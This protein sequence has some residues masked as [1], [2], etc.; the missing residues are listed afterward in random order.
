[1]KILFLVKITSEYGDAVMP[2]KSG[3]RN[4]A[5]FVVDA[6]NQ[7]TGVHAVL[8]LCRD[9]NSIDRFIHHFKPQICIIE[10]IWV[11]PAK[12]RE[13]IAKY[14]H[15]RF[16]V[17]VH[18]K[19]P[20]LA[21]EGNAIEWIK[22]YS[23]EAIISFN[24]VDI[25]NDYQ[26]IG[27]HNTYLPNIY[28]EVLHLGCNPVERRRNFYRVGCFGALRPLKNQLAQAV[29]ALMFAEKRHATLHFY[30]NSTRIE[31]RGDS[32][33]KNMRALF[34]GTRHKLF[35]IDWLE[36]A[37]FV[38]VIAKMDVCMQVS[39]TETFNIVTADCIA[40]HVPVVVSEEIYWLNC[41]KAEPTS[42]KSIAEVLD[43]AIHN[44]TEL[45]EDNI[46]DLKT[47]NHHAILR[48]FRFINRD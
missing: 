37:E 32:V 8:E 28:P 12:L 30:I 26:Q 44:K 25:G 6:I 4:S 19:T 39:F 21:M 42:E 2:S 43:Y 23:K 10:A 13:L 9:G 46:Q 40:A 27:I 17:R 48:W 18:S 15:I 22:E 11:T 1:M 34:A 36:H 47:Y 33:L 35:E 29:A 20:F 24:S 38:K 41:R 14:P 3:L 16:V 45:V 7:F 5:R 31:Q